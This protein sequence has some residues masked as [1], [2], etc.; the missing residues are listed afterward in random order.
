VKARANVNITTTEP[1]DTIPFSPTVL[2]ARHCN[3]HHLRNRGIGFQ[4]NAVDRGRH[5]IQSD[6]KATN[7]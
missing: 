1:D 7:K 4:G 5:P 2:C 3:D 6:D